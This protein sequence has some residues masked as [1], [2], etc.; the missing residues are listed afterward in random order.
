MTYTM[1]D[2]T[3]TPITSTA[4][5][6]VTGTNDLPT[7]NVDTDVVNE[8][9]SVTVDVLA[10]DTD[11]DDGATLT[12]DTV[13]SD[14]GT[15]SIVDGKLV[16]TATAADFDHLANGVEE[17]VVVT[18]TMS[19]ETG[20][21]ITST[22][23][24]TV[25]GTN[26]L[27]TAN[28]DTDVV[29]E[30]NSVTVDV[31]AN[32]TD[33]DDGATLTLD[34]VASDKGTVSIVDGKLVF[35]ATA[36][37]FDHLANG[38]EEEVV[39][40]YT[41]S[42]ETGTPITSTA[43]ITVT[44][45]N[46]LPTANVDT[47]VVNENNS[48]TV[49]VLAN[50]TDLDDGATLTLDTVASDKGTVS[51]VDGKLV[52][53]ATAADFDHL[54]NG[55]EE[56]VVV[57]YTM[58]DETGTP[59]TSTATITVTG[60]N[61]LPTANVDTDVVNENN[62][63]TVDVLAND[64]DLDDGATLTL[65]TVASDKGTVSIV[66]G[67]LVFTATA[68]DF[69]H[70]ANGVEEEV[71]VTY[72]MSD[73]TGTPIT[74]TATI[75]VTGT[76]DLPTANV[77]TDVV[78]ENNSVTV[79]VLANDTDLDDGATLTLDT[80]ASDKGTVS[81]VDGKLVFTATA[82]DFDHLANGVEEEVVVTY[83][84]SDETG[85]PITSTATIT[86][87]GTNDLPT[88]NVDT[89]VVNENNSV[90]VDVLANDTDL[91]DGATLTLDTVASDK[92]TVSIVDGKLVFTATAADFDHLANGVEEEVV[93]T[94]TM[95]DET[96][97][98]ITST[99]T[100]TV[101]GTNDLP[102]ANVDTDVVNENNSVT[103]DVLA[104]D[105]DLD[106][107]ATLTLDTVASDKGT[108]SIVDG[109]LVFTA[110][111]ADF[112]HLAN[113]VEEEVVV[114][115]TM[116]D[117]TGTPITSTA[118][119]TVTGT[120]DLP[121][122]NVDTDVVNE[123]N[124][125]TVD[126]LANDT[127]LDDGATLTLDT[128]ASDKGTVSIVDG[129]LVFTATA[130]DFDHLANG[131]EEEVVVTYTMSDETGTPITSTATI[132]VTGT[133]DLPTANV[134][135]DVV[136][137]NNSVTVDVLANDTDLD[138]GATLTLDT[139]ASDKGTVS[140]VDGKLVF[141][142]TAADFD[143][144]ANGVEEEV[145]VTY[146]M[147]DETG[148]P[149]TSTATITVT[150]TNDLPT[151]N[152]DTDVVNENNSVTVD[153]LANDTDLDDGATLTLDTVAS[154][155][156]TV[157]IVDGK[158][159][160][161]ATAADF[162]HLANGVEEEVV[163]T[164]TMSDETGTP[165]TSTATITVT[166]T[167]DLPTA[168]VDTD[169]V[170][171]NNSVTVDVLAND[172][173]LDDGATLTLDTV[174]SD[175]GTVSIVDGKLVFTAT[176]ADFDHL[177]NGVEEEVVVTYTM[178]DETGT[179]ITSTATITVTGTNDL[180]TANVDTD[181]VN[182]NNSVTVDV[183]A[184]DT[185]LD[186][187]ATLTL[188]TVASDKGTVS[189][190]DGKLVFTATAA[191]FDHLANGVEE[192]VVVT[193]TMSDETGTPI[194][195]TA[196]ITVTGTN[197]LPTANVDT[198]VVNENN[199]V[200]VDVLANDTDLDDGA[201]LT[202]D[203]VASDKGTVSIVDGKLVFTATAAD[204]D[205]L[206][207]G[208]EEEV[209]VTYTMSD[210]TGTPI[211]STATITVT[212]TNDLPTA[213]VDTDVVNENNSVTVDVLA[214]DTDLDDGATLTL[215]TVASDKGTVSIVDGKLVFT[216]TAADFDHLAN[217]VE[218]EV[219]V[220]Y[221]M[222]DETG[223]PIT[224]TATITVTGT[225][226]LPTANVDTD[227]VNENNS[228]TVDVLAND[229]D[230]DDGA[231]LTLDTVA[232]DKG[233]VSIVDGK[234]VFTATAADFDH[235]ANGVEEEVVVTYTMSDETG[236]PITSTATIT[237][238][239]TNDLPTA[240]VDTDVVN[241]N[242]SVTVD[243][244]ANDT[245][246]DDGATLTLDTVASDKGTVSIVD[247]KLVFTA[248]AADFDHLA[249][250]VEE[251]VVVTYTMSDET[252]TPITSTATITVTG[253]N[254]LPT[255]NVDTDVVNENNS[256]TVDV[257]ANDT[258]LDDGATLTLDT[259]ASDKGTVSIVDGKLVFTATAADFDHLANGVEEEVV[260]TYTMSDETGTPIT[261][262]A[263]I[264][265]TG[266]NDL[267]TA[268]V[269]TDVVNEN[270]SVTVDVLANDTDLDDGATLTLDTVASDKGTVSIVDGK[271]VF[272]A[273]AADFDHLANGV[274]EE[275]VVTYTMSDE[276]G[277]PITSTATITVTGTNDLPT[278]NVDTDVV[279]ENNSVTVDVLANDTDLDDG[280]T[281]TLDTVA[282]D[283]GTVS[284]VDGKLVFTATAA[285][286]DHLANGVEEEV[287][288]TYTMSDETGTPITSTATITVT[289][290]NDLPTANVDT[291]VVNENNSVTV[292]V[293]ANDTDLDDGAT[294]TLDTVASD[295]GT[296]SIVDG[297]LVFTATAADFDHLANGVEEEVVV[298]YTMSDET[299][300]PITSTATITV[301][302]TN[303][304]PTANVDTDVVNEN[305]SVTVDVLANDTDLDDGATLTL[306]TVAS[307]KGTVSIVDG[308]LVFTATAAD[309]DHLAN[310]VEEEVVVTYT[311]SD[312]T[313]TP[314]TSTATIT[315][316]G[317]NDLPTANV[318]TDVVNENNSVTV[319]VLANDTDLDDG[320]TLTLDTVASDKGT[321]SIVDGKLVFTA[322]AA[323]FDH[324]ANGVEE[325]V[326]VTYT[327]SDETGTPIT[328]T[329]TITV[330]G[331][332][333]LPTANVDTDVVN[334]NNSVTVDV[335][336]NDTDLDDGATLTLDTVASDKGTVS[337]VDGKL[338]FTATAA[339]F[340][341][342]ANG[343]EEEVVVTYT[344]SDETGTP[345][346]STA[347]ITVTGTN[348]LP[349][350]NV[351]TDV[352]N[353]NNSVTVDVLAND[354]DLDDGATLTLDT[355]ASDKGTV[356]IVDG[357]LV[358]TATAAD[359]DHLANGVEEEVVVTYT[360]SDETG[361]PITSTATITVTGTNDLPTANVDTDVVNENNSVTVDVLANDT[362][363]DDGA[364][365]TLDTVASDKG[366]VSIVDGK[367]VFTA[368]AADFDHLAN[369]VEEEVVVTY[370]MSD[371]TGTPITS[372]ATITV[373]GTNDLPTANVDT[374]VVN[375]NNSVTVDVLA[376]DTDLDDGATLTL[377]TVASD[378]GTVSIVDGKLVFTATAADFDHLANGV[379]EEV[380]VTY[381]MSDET[382]TPITSTATIT[383]T[384][385]N[386]LPTANVDTDV[387]NENNS[388][389]VDVLANDTD[390][391]DGATL[392]LDTVA[393]DKGTVSIVDGKLVFT[394]TAA[395]FDHLANGVEEEVVVTYTMSDET[396]TPITSTA[397]ITVTG[398]NDLPTA[399]VDTD[400]VNENNSV[401]VDVLANDTDLDDG[402]TL[403]L[404]TV[405]SD[406]GTVSIVDG[407]LVFTATAADFDHLANGVE[408]EVVVTYTMSDET[409]TPITSTA[410]ITVTGTN[411]LPTANVDTDVVN[412]NNSVTV[413]VL[414]ND[415]DLD[416]GA[417][418]TLDTVA[419]DKGTV[420]IV[421][422][423]LVFTATAADFDHLANG[424]E[425]EVVVTYTMSDETGTPITSTATI[426][427]TG[428]NDLPTALDFS[429]TL[430]NQ[431]EAFFTFD[432]GQSGSQDNVGDVEDDAS[433][434]SVDVKIL[435]EPLFGN[436]YDVS[437]GGKVLIEAGDIISSDA[438]VE[439]EQDPNAVD[440]LDFVASTFAGQVNNGSSSVSYLQGNVLISSGIYDGS[441]PV[442]ANVVDTNSYLVYD[443]QNQED[444]FGVST[445]AN[446]T[447]GEL[448]VVSGG[449]Q[450]YISVDYSQ[451]GATITE[452]N[453]DFGSVFGN[454][455][456]GNTAG[457]RIN[458][459]ALDSDGNVVGTFYFD[460][461]ETG[462]HALSIDNNG[463]AT[464]NVS[465]PD[466]F[467]ELRVFTTQDGS[468]DPDKNSNI[469]LK[470]VDVVSAELTEEIDYKSVDSGGLLSDETAQ[471]TITDNSAGQ[472]PVAQDDTVS[473]FGGLSG[474][475]YG[476]NDSINGNIDS[477]QDALNVISSQ[478]ADLTFEA[479]DINYTLNGNTNGLSSQAQFEDFLNSDA[480]SL[481][482]SI[483]DHTDGVI[484]MSG[485][486][487]LEQ[488]DFA[489]KVTADDG[490]TILI[491]GVAVATVDQNQSST[492]TL[493]DSFTID[494]SG[495]HSIEVVY[496]DQGGAANLD[497]NLG[498]VDGNGNY[499]NGEHDLND[500]PLIGDVLSVREGES[501]TVDSSLLVANDYDPNT[502]DSFTIVADGFSSADGTVSYDQ[503]SGEITFTP[504]S[505]VTGSASFTYTIVD[506]SGL[507][508]TAVVTTSVTPISNGLVV[509]ADLAALSSG[510]SDDVLSFVS[511]VQSTGQA[512]YNNSLYG[513]G[514]N[515]VTDGT[516]VA[517]TNSG[518]LIEYGSG[519]HYL[520][521]GG[522]GNDILL[523]GS[524]V[525]DI[526]D[527][528]A[529]DDILVGSALDG[530]SIELRGDSISDSGD[531]ILVSQNSDRTTAYRGLDGTDVAYLPASSSELEYVSGNGQPWDF[532][533][534]KDVD[535][536][537]DNNILANHDFYGLET[538]YL[539][540]GK[541]DVSDGQL[542]KVSEVFELSI[543]ID[544]Y[545]NDGSEQVT[546]L[547]IS[548][549]PS[550]VV[551]SIGA[552][553]ADGTWVIEPS[554][555]DGEGKLTVIVE[556]PVNTT[557]VLTVT[558]GAQ[559][560]DDQGHALDSEMYADTQTGTIF[561]A[562][563]STNGDNT[564]IGFDGD[565]VLLGDTGGVV[566]NSVAP[567]NY[568]IALVVDTSGSMRDALN[569]NSSQSKL[570]VVKASLIAM[571]ADIAS[572]PGIIN[573]ALIG[574][575]A[576]ASI[577]IDLQ[578]LE[579][580][581]LE[582]TVNSAINDLT[583]DGATNYEAAFDSAKDWFADDD[584]PSSYE[585]LTFFL[586]DGKPTVSNSSNNSGS[587]TQFDEFADSV[588]AFD[589][590]ADV[591]K[592]RTIGIGDG[593]DSEILEHFVSDNG[594]SY[595]YSSTTTQLANFSSSTGESWSLENFAVS[596]GTAVLTSSS[597][598]LTDTGDINSSASMT[599]PEFVVASGEAS[600]LTFDASQG[601]YFGGGDT[602]GWSVQKFD[603]QAQAW[604]SVSS[605][606]ST[607][608]IETDLLH[609]GKYQ[610]VLSVYEDQSGY[611]A[612]VYLDNFA[613][614]T[615][616]STTGDVEIVQSSQG[617]DA[618]LEEGSNE[619]TLLPVGSDDLSGGAGNDILFGDVINT[620]N[621]PWDDNGLVR[622]DALADGSGMEALTT[623][624]Q[625]LNGAEPT[626]MEIYEYVKD[627]HE[628][629]NADSDTR[630][631]DDT[632]TGGL[633]DD[634][635]YGQ[636][637]E[638][639]LIGG[640]GDDILVGGDGDDLFQWVDE[641]F[642][643]DVDTITD[644]ALGED[645]LDISQLLP[646]E[647]SMS[648]LLEHI[649]IEKVDNGGGDKDLVIT[650]SEDASNSSQTQTIV[651]DNTGNQ[652]DSVNA[653]G[654]GSVISSDL[655]NLVNQLFV[656]LPDQ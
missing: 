542:T 55:V 107:G 360:M 646:T 525:N 586:T 214:N 645:H 476:S 406:K 450:E 342:L 149:I 445:N 385:T 495:Y 326:V 446:S 161:T 390:L 368:T 442:D 198:D 129:K 160:F 410:T 236:T 655:S 245:D 67:K 352:V 554:E 70:L 531:D 247:G 524:S 162:D 392:T 75:T 80:V 366:T 21:P 184:N 629:F 420:S 87:T 624:L 482:G 344:M 574:F 121:T 603:E 386:D 242:N 54:A 459:L 210:E 595:T 483:A 571:L 83:T 633:G 138:D 317:T 171:E 238:T 540:D 452:A 115:Y 533:L 618:A 650:I 585:N 145:V 612:D 577:E 471:L 416:D 606:S 523:G 264:T 30:N 274:E 473:V 539:Q 158:L 143:H 582:Q 117:E 572:H 131:V 195:S 648:D 213:N 98:P 112:D 625:M 233:T 513:D 437:G 480:S 188:D 401:T 110:T 323:D 296:V 461:D 310:G 72:T 217:G 159:V 573:L 41:M 261:S 302:G 132:T 34:T 348:D 405:A 108:V 209:V 415:T 69:D 229:T 211:T 7:A 111:A 52:F 384:G 617:L 254:D 258:D 346:T 382:G 538:L 194:T 517:G 486:I 84:M 237:V 324:L 363:L 114:T 626:D 259:V 620:D 152:V 637:G 199:S 393:S 581:D 469:T 354:T 178:S 529:G 39:V 583:A 137:E 165:I 428:T 16:F 60:T 27:P 15:V 409:G 20:T 268:N 535:G 201:T 11:L 228:V 463:N 394:A 273:T 432:G 225:N 227:V 248:T 221:T 203:T 128:V 494:S 552:K 616:T 250:G 468:D 190:V 635:L 313:G 141:T 31:L 642:Q 364:T 42:D 244:L 51:I 315:V 318:D 96:G 510:V 200:T 282:S 322:T 99:A 418:L 197:D 557:P 373:T 9:N 332:N 485:S 647:N 33:L 109:K 43:T 567:T 100:I 176:A 18:Y 48:V 426:T 182:E 562:S 630:G 475:Y 507:T 192:E 63:V 627:N 602:F 92:G 424:V 294:L 490:Y 362:D 628:L 179:P 338:V 548:D 1:S 441:S 431:D 623:F 412:E 283:K 333:D 427:V 118:T 204:F 10:N 396:G 478:D 460:S 601:S 439:Y 231:T 181:V 474:Y 639:T 306:D 594:S 157:S 321:V 94:Y 276:T 651:L 285:D 3:G 64:T 223:T 622:P 105:T 652:F 375:E 404:D 299:G 222:S 506:S 515:I 309:F 389:T 466:G 193:Y 341:H 301:T 103:V 135:T 134:D 579:E 279:N 600:V 411:D 262:T 493:H 356:S 130:A 173:D 76:N 234:L 290:T 591:S 6:T 456:A 329:A 563:E 249:N 46:D 224:S 304:L 425:E 516:Q 243:V 202:L 376:N 435:E 440:K 172:T 106:D 86:V 154:D 218:E 215:D 621:L 19:D 636:G 640:L 126:V 139:V 90:T 430:D 37:D 151:A 59:I 553:Q 526:I 467:T 378:K 334:E 169:V 505:N 568:N 400:V 327:M 449:N 632:I 381:T 125:V 177:A 423:K 357:K 380:V 614:K 219:V 544:L 260:V 23:T 530:G 656:N 8:N 545:D 549:V 355:V 246:L 81:I 240:N 455:N 206:A 82:A 611:T 558:A 61:D 343:V 207:N 534:I 253:T 504:N 570:A 370:T 434:T 293:L 369:G 297:K 383:V 74:S 556:A 532:R 287:V 514:A 32:D 576:S 457:G 615:V 148:T 241:E 444:G 477:V 588:T 275:V 596:G 175:K 367:L 641:P 127:D 235:L 45:T 140:I 578:N 374:D 220:T 88:A 53:T 292:D 433:G 266:T 358:F 654:D 462:D 339:D 551:L 4:T 609:E 65:D 365:L 402:A 156:G 320:A 481:E 589:E 391:D 29:N 604:V 136:N 142:A 522:E 187:G 251:E 150:G 311:M 79:D 78:N 564:I 230:L 212:G 24:I 379:E 319:D 350:A 528:G 453:I 349:T 543:D 113:G 649:T 124:S 497:I 520:A 508:D 638:D 550:D 280:A 252:G 166:G 284:I 372:T 174:A 447:S 472:S 95:S 44:G 17:E 189:I 314:I 537:P 102:T 644:F 22:A 2:E 351:D 281:L 438:Q 93:V 566:D 289:G 232:S 133:N 653:Q 277:T 417:T 388:V 164:Y 316:T 584:Q 270:N 144:L 68:A 337:I 489:F 62:S 49:D 619:I 291:D 610:L 464:V 167:N 347:T 458:V 575:E 40:T 377:D 500:F 288:V 613:I 208:V 191:D 511:Q 421:D 257:L 399:N 492:T 153:V 300:T 547:V 395:D 498:T 267:P 97:T 116:S 226:D 569:N 28:V 120:N 503:N 26:D 295:K 580:S 593:I 414:A 239:G 407:K 146:T 331:T 85:T 58:S 371:E 599:S 429:V 509:S 605:G 519:T 170:N 89:D 353:E 387:V 413:D 361:T 123:N 634:I 345:I 398:T 256:V 408:E 77:D 47:D 590:L 454:Y 496:W 330:T 422:G 325:E 57:T 35:T 286:F 272:T 470:G 263:T 487:Y 340:D 443:S 36:A 536:D 546:S 403:T 56:E 12:L 451:S 512:S 565:D 101:T 183:L 180:P 397:T 205:H 436:L 13:A 499:N 71:V 155:K 359:F 269:D 502:G 122:A 278:A 479:R 643:G 561:T 465:V 163:V 491:D 66:D 336:A 598:L 608:S 216:A 119:I 541:F 50:D 298:T 521:N 631:G 592:V 448:D 328:S 305:N 559:E 38:V 501:L 484:K 147:S 104:N 186:D 265:V 25:T 303:D 185:D 527:G 91:D 307:D 312:E 255:A 196:T 271:L 518:D 419:S 597:I 14:K 73:E 587:T 308:K 488:G 607:G 335:L 5:I 560:V 168:N 555:L